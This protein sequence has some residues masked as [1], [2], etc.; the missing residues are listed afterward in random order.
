[1]VAAACRFLD[2]LID[3]G[4]SPHTICAYA[5]DLRRLFTFLHCTKQADTPTVGAGA[6]DDLYCDSGTTTRGK[7]SGARTLPS[8]R[9]CLRRSPVCS[10]SQLRQRPVMRMS[11]YW[12]CVLGFVPSTP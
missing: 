6:L 7:G 9:H 4:F 10:P 8:P 12:Q 1:M 3:R 11:L 5:Y 2:H